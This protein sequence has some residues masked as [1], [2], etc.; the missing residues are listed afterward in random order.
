M[1]KI[2]LIGSGGSGKS[3]LARELGQ[4][5]GIEVHHL[6]AYFWRPGWNLLNADERR[7]LQAPILKRD[8][9]IIDGN[10]QGSMDD[11]LHEAD[12]ILFLDLPRLLCLFRVVKRRIRYHGVT[13]PD[14]HPGC[15]E[16]LD[17]TFLKWI[18]T[19]P[20]VIRPDV[21]AQLAPLANEKRVLRLTSRHAVKRFLDEFEEGRHDSNR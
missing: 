12:T 7:A 4:K 13:R 20:Q 14:M 8:T 19:Y 6:D 11:R 9:W 1:R 15:E 3:T 10:Y 18:W 5:L 17:R 21:L 2:M 16:R